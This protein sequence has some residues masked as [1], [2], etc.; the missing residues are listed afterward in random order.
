MK[1]DPSIISDLQS[2]K[3]GVMP[4]DTIFGIVALAINPESI[5]RIYEAKGRPTHKRVIHLISDMSQL[6]L[7]GIY[8]TDSHRVTLNTIWPG[9]VSVDLKCDDT[10]PHSHAGEYSIAVRMPKDQWLRDLLAQTGPLIATSA[11]KSGLPTPDNLNEIKTQLPGLDFYVDG[12]VG[13]TPSRLAR[14]S[15]SGEIT[16]L[17]R[18]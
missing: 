9:P 14:L 12:P 8:P 6:E 2:G 17:T 5:A 11:N 15:D 4:T 16:W 3:I 7:L 1:I 18:S 13:S 10:L